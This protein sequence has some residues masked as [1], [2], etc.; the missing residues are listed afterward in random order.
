MSPLLP[1]TSKR[2]MRTLGFEPFPD[3]TAPDFH[4]IDARPHGQ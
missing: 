1:L 2:R 3:R 4:N